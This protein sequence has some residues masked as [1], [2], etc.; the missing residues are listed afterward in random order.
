MTC[1][2]CEA[3]GTTLRRGLCAP[4]RGQKYSRKTCVE[5]EKT[6]PSGVTKGCEGCAERQAI[7]ACLKR[8]DALDNERY[9]KAAA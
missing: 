6:N 3:H 1:L 7:R 4:A 9:G 5:C 2:N 8:R